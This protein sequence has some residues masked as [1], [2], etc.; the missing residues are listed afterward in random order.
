MNASF[1]CGVS[2]KKRCDRVA[3][4]VGILAID[5]GWTIRIS[6]YPTWTVWIFGVPKVVGQRSSPGS[7]PR[8]EVERVSCSKQLAQRKG[9]TK[10]ETKP[11]RN[12]MK[13]P[14][15]QNDNGKSTRLKMYFLLNNGILQCHVGFPR[16]TTMKQNDWGMK[17]WLISKMFGLPAYH[18]RLWR[19]HGSSD[20]SLSENTR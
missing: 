4:L 8:N 13:P 5:K 16:W 10:K 18:Y 15:H 17:F 9:A 3:V 1:V 2:K 20:L 12:Q 19:G 11:K 7:M 6:G 14:K